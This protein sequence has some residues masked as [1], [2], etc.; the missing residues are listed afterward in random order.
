MA[1]NVAGG[2]AEREQA[3]GLADDEGMYR[4]REYQ[5]VFARLLQHFIELVDDH[6]S[7]LVAGVAPEDERRRIVDFERVRDRQDGS[8]PRP[9]PDRLI[10][11]CPIHDIAIAGF[12]Q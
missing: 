5:W 4:D 7:E 1:H 3:K 6:L 2:V 10:V 12:L 11:H 8:A 9:H